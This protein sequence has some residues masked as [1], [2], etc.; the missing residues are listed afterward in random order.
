MSLR[1]VQR[2]S[3]LKSSGDAVR[4]AHHVLREHVTELVQEST[5]SPRR[6]CGFAQIVKTAF[7]LIGADGFLFATDSTLMWPLLTEAEY[8]AK[9]RGLSTDPPEPF[10]LSELDTELIPGG[11][12]ARLLRL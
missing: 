10:R 6:F 9:F 8:V 3:N 12:T 4:F 1:G 7:N 5:K 11:D 2:R